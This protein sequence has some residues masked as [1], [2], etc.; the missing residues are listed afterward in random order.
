MVREESVGP[1]HDSIIGRDVEPVEKSVNL[2]LRLRDAIGGRLAVSGEQGGVDRF[3]LK[4][5][6]R[7]QRVDD[8]E[9][10]I[11]LVGGVSVEHHRYPS[12]RSVWRE[13]VML[14]GIS[15]VWC[16]RTALVEGVGCELRPQDSEQSERTNQ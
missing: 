6:L 11:D 5:V 16:F 10:V 7:K 8:R 14:H 2:G 9:L 15:V 1:A 3:E 4:P 12:R 13:D